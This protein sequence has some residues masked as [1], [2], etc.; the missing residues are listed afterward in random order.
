MVR[1]NRNTAHPYPVRV[2][3]RLDISKIQE[4]NVARRVAFNNTT[5][6]G[7]EVPTIIGVSEA[8]S[9]VITTNFKITDA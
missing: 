4:K 7:T 1:G 5:T 6:R 8:F 9:T 3:S 2:A